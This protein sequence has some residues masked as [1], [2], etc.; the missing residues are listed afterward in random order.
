[1]RLLELSDLLAEHFDNYDLY[2]AGSAEFKAALTAEPL[3]DHLYHALGEKVI[4]ENARLKEAGGEEKFFLRDVS[5]N[6]DERMRESLAFYGLHLFAFTF[7]TPLHI[8][9]LARLMREVGGDIHFWHLSSLLHG[10]LGCR[11]PGEYRFNEL[12]EIRPPNEDIWGKWTRASRSF[13]RTL[14][15]ENGSVFLSPIFAEEKQ[16]E[17]PPSVRIV[18]APGILREIE[19][20]YNSILYHISRDETLAL[21]DFMI[22]MP[23]PAPYRAQIEMVFTGRAGSDNASPRLPYS[24]I[25]SKGGGRSVWLQALR[26]LLQLAES[27]S[28]GFLRARI[29]PLLHNDCILAAFG[30]KRSD[31]EYYVAWMD[32]LGVYGGDVYPLPQ[33]ATGGDV[34]SPELPP[35]SWARALTRLRLGRV[36][37][38]DEGGAWRG[39]TP[40]R[41]AASGDKAVVKP[42]L[43]LLETLSFELADL[44]AL[45]LSGSAWA[46]RLRALIA[47]FIALPDHL[48]PEEESVP[49]SFA[50]ELE[51]LALLPV[52]GFALIKSLVDE[53]C[54]G[55]LSGA[56]RAQRGRAGVRTADLSELH[57]HPAAYIYLLGMNE[58][59]Y[60]ELRKQRVFDL[61]QSDLQKY[62]ADIT[63]SDRQRMMFAET[64]FSAR[65][66]IYI[67]YV[68]KDIIQDSPLYPSSLLLELQT[69]LSEMPG[70]PDGGSKVLPLPLSGWTGAAGEVQNTY[71]DVYAT[72]FKTHALLAAC[73]TGSERAGASSRHIFPSASSG[74]FA[75]SLALRGCG[76]PATT[77]MLA[78]G[79][80]NTQNERKSFSLSDFARYFCDPA[81]GLLPQSLRQRESV[82][83]KIQRT[84][85]EPFVPDEASSGI[86]YAIRDSLVRAWLVSGG[87]AETDKF[88]EE[89]FN[90]NLKMRFEEEGHIPSGIFAEGYWDKLIHEKKKGFCDMLPLLADL[91]G[92][93]ARQG[94][95]LSAPFVFGRVFREVRDMSLA[96]LRDALVV[97]AHDTGSEISGDIPL[98]W[99]E[100]EDVC[101]FAYHNAPVKALKRGKRKLSI[102]AHA[103]GQAFRSVLAFIPPFAEQLAF[104]KC[105]RVK[106]F[107]IDGNILSFT[108]DERHDRAFRQAYTNLTEDNP[109]NFFLA[110]LSIVQACAERGRLTR[111]AL[112]LE[113]QDSLADAWSPQWKPSAAV[114][115][116]TPPL[117]SDAQL[118]AWYE[119][120][121]RPF[122]D[123]LA[124][125]LDEDSSPEPL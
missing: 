120:M 31:L 43:V 59:V 105:A 109:E 37:R 25:E 17:L 16:D 41:D 114:R 35:H 57:F 73:P 54:D 111:A 32:G 84:S 68:H 56:R 78:S 74:D 71:P 64:L 60:P 11:E 38:L 108:L 70:M 49:E 90:E 101:Y 20:V 36:L 53:I 88:V 77:R 5:P 23:D 113:L 67:S 42:L 102:D 86:K 30:A 95:H 15:L 119:G 13:I 22:L 122:I 92:R 96:Y 66:G 103:L 117:P 9:V 61:R 75:G 85:S 4:R 83:R 50:R 104:P 72:H 69:L 76:L 123:A 107:C 65:R 62:P 63:E 94:E 124:A 118:G 98:L 115:L 29:L 125:G 6:P 87:G 27:M 1:V 97:R 93:I 2:R 26:S 8:R 106:M 21:D 7:L 18:G 55:I 19:F 45:R 116:G 79:S 24:S 34:V 14:A 81:E 80:Q 28:C 10:S 48:V 3:Q 51:K 46:E 52:C 58:G 110:P 47:R 121:I 89:Y 40:Y 112:L 82:F 100:G 99:R 12:P 91:P 44:S 33:K 39:I